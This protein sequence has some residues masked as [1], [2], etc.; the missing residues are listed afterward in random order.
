MLSVITK[1][2][3]PADQQNTTDLSHKYSQWEKHIAQGYKNH[4]KREMAQAI[5]NFSKSLA[6]SE[7]VRECFFA[8]PITKSGIAMMYSS[9]HNLAASLNTQHKALQAKHIL[10]SFHEHLV[11]ILLNPFKAKKLRFEALSY[12]DKSLFSVSSQL[13]YINEVE[14]IH[15]LILRTEEIATKVSK[16]LFDHENF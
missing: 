6:L 9:S 7:E 14:N 1:N 12:L 3:L 4:S 5:N 10:L 11:E 16:Q 15:A 13:A 8:D 2:T